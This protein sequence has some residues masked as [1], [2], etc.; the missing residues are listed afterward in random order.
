MCLAVPMR[1]VSIDGMMARCEAKGIER[2]VNLILLQHEPLTAGDMVMVHVGYAIQTMSEEE[3]SASWNLI[4]EMLAEEERLAADV[5]P[6][7]TTD[8]ANA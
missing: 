5:S 1:I 3:A 8:N 4:D 6:N 2:S 7:G